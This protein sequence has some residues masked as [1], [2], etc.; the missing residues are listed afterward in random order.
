MEFVDITLEKI[1]GVAVITFIRE[2][3]RNAVRR[4][5]WMDLK[6]AIGAARDDDIVRAVV[7]TGKGKAF[8]AGA[9]LA[10]MGEILG[11]QIDYFAV[12]KGLLEIQDITR[13]MVELKK[14]I[15]AALNGYAVGAGAE[16]AIASDIRIASREG[17]V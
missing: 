13:A 15:V 3:A 7:I 2:Q 8:S 16:I 5:T 9:D 4:Q 6:K 12:R 17:N 10:E 11:G 14:P 1:D